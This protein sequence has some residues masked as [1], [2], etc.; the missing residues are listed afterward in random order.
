MDLLL[1][2]F[3]INLVA[4]VYCIG[5]AVLFLPSVFNWNRPP[6]IPAL[7]PQRK[8]VYSLLAT[9]QGTIVEIGCGCYPMI[10]RYPSST[11]G[12]ELSKLAYWVA[13]SMTKI[14]RSKM[15]IF[16]GDAFKVN[17]S[18]R[19][20]VLYLG[21]EMTNRYVATLPRGSVVISV[22]FPV[23]KLQPI[24]IKKTWMGPVYKYK[25]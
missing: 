15:K 25:L 10:L 3:V 19:V 17:L 9:E 11:S 8:A 21:D 14:T 22:G 4:L 2:K 6:P 20:F 7:Y 5:L 16:Y 18:G 13:K 23:H 12:V 1:L 24:D